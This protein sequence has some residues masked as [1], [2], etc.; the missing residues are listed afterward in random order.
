MA[1]IIPYDPTAKKSATKPAAPTNTVKIGSTYV[2][3]RN[4]YVVI[5]TTNV[6]F[7]AP[8]SKKIISI[9]IPKS[10]KIKGKTYKVTA[11]GNKAFYGCKKLKKVI[12][13][14]PI[15]KIGKYAF[16]K[17]K[18]LK[19][20][21]IYSKKLKKKNVLTGAFKGISKKAVF[22][23]PKGKK[24]AYKRIFLKRGAKKSVKFKRN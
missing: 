22:Y 19:S 7:K 18:K 24:A 3:K 6:R 20:I 12:I 10:V 23:C 13:K 2:V 21:R 9:R 14:S 8:A 5:S 16:Y 15:K 17:C 1:R 4:K 11:I